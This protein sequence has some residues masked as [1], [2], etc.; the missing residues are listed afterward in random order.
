MLTP[1]L[2]A[3]SLCLGLGLAPGERVDLRWT[4]PPDCPAS[5]FHAA[6]APYLGPTD[7]AAPLF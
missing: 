5:V 4:G 7:P 1:S 6:L 2:A 3:A